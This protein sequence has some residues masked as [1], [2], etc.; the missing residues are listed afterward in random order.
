M[1]DERIIKN[2]NF[3]NV[4]NGVTYEDTLSGPGGCPHNN[5]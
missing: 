4:L 2:R 1:I 3:G 5:I